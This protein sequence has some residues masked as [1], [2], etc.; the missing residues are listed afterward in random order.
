MGADTDTKNI[1]T[2][3]EWDTRFWGFPIARIEPATL[4]ST[5]LEEVLAWCSAHEIRCLYFRADGSCPRTLALA[6][7]GGFRFVDVRVELDL[8]LPVPPIT[9][10][11][12]EPDIVRPATV[13]DLPVLREL[14]AS[15]HR[16]S[17]F[18]KDDSFDAKRVGDLY[19]AWIDRDFVRHFVLTCESSKH[20]GQP[21]GY[22]TCVCHANSTEGQIGLIAVAPEHVGR[23][24]GTRL[25]HAALNWFEKEGLRTVKVVTQ[26]PNV[27]AMRLYETIG[28]RTSNV[29]LWFHK[30]LP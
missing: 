24:L 6:F 15:A 2:L 29:T 27:R 18:F 22:V 14:A 9:H 30:W 13:E 7:L 17:R 1:C 8:S 26:A 12:P 20:P 11:N 19:R 16:D 10:R 5:A 28:F 4:S 3:L 21:C 25:M 23:G